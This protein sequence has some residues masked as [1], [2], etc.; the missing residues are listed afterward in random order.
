MTE[1]ERTVGQ[2]IVIVQRSVPSIATLATQMEV[3]DEHPELTRAAIL[4][5]VV[6]I[7][8]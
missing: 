8:I 5:R 7:Y 2:I 6:Y 4:E 3:V 1:I